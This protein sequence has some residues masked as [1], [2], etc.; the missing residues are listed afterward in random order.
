MAHL[1]F[2][3]QVE[4][5]VRAISP[6]DLTKFVIEQFRVVHG[7]KWTAKH[8]CEELKERERPQSGF[9]KNENQQVIDAQTP[10]SSEEV[11]RGRRM[12]SKGAV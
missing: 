5:D 2:L 8:E 4:V 9:V 10:K 11:G 7:M 3:R 1:G 12:G 6:K